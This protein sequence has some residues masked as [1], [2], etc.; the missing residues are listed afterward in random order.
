MKTY[1]PLSLI[2]ALGENRVIG[3]DNS[4]PWHLPADFKYFKATTLGK[5]IIMG[6][7]TWDSLGR[8]LPGRLN[9][10]VSRQRDLQLQ[11]AEVFASLDAAVVRAEQWA[12]EQ[13][14][15]EVMLIG[16]AQLYA[17]GLGQADRLYLTRVALSPDGDAWFPE[18]DRAQW[19]LVSN[20]Q[21]SALDDKPAYSFEVWERTKG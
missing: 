13:G 14:A 17:Q 8:P 16:G 9:L 5:P 1:L 19:T 20:T 6:R 15:A 11:G 21:S 18:F 7:K 2:A 10:V 3:V 12:L 4:M